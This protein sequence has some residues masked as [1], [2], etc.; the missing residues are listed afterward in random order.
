MP[1]CS[2]KTY[3]VYGSKLSTARSVG[4]ALRSEAIGGMTG[5]SAA[6]KPGTIT[7]SGP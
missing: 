7:A 1:S 4:S 2:A 5:L 3:E 6:T